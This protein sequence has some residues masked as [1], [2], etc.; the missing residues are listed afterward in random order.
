MDKQA[1]LNGSSFS[2]DEK[3]GVK[4][5]LKYLNWND[6]GYYTLYSLYMQLP[7]TSTS[8]MIADMQVMNIGQKTGKRPSWE[9][10]PPTVFISDVD[11]AE[12]MFLILTPEQRLKLEEILPIRYNSQ[13]I[14]KEQVFIQSVMRGITMTEFLN[15]QNRIKELMHSTIDVSTLI[16]RHKTQINLFLSGIKD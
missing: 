9:P 2:L 3:S 11:S 7:D 6:Y 13:H 1:I 10:T 14:E 4:F 15:R 12:R 5:W 16:C 8:Y